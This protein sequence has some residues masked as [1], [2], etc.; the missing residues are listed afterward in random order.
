[1]V[2]I[3]GGGEW[4]TA[5]IGVGNK[6]TIFIYKELHFPY[7]IGLLYS[8]Y[9]YFLGFKVNLG[10]YKF[11]GLAPC[12][13]PGSEEVFMNMAHEAKKLTNAE[14]L[15]LAGGVALKCAAN[16]RLHR[17]G[18]FKSIFIQLADGDDGGGYWCS[19]DNF[20]YLF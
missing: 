16:G 14:H 19:F 11:M 1:M 18:L 7:S 4:A 5:S 15:C 13:I 12:G 3:D 9:T 8:A 6:N 17:S 2:P 10:E 20:S